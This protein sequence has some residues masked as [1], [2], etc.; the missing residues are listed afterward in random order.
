MRVTIRNTCRV[1]KGEFDSVLCLGEQYVSNFLLPEQ[2]DGV[3]VPLELVL[4]RQCGLLQLR[5][6][7]AAEAMYQN[8]WYRSGTNKTMRNALA[9][10]ANTAERLINLR[11]GEAVLDIGCNDGTLLSCYKTPDIFR[12]GF[13]PAENLA[14]FS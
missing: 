6:T 2:P 10:I 7:V 4:C 13:D 8:Y 14:V 12:I 11:P 3:K 9:E 5:H 1:C